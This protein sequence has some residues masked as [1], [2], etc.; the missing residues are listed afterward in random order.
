MRDKPS[1]HFLGTVLRGYFAEAHLGKPVTPSGIWDRMCME[2]I[3]IPGEFTHL[4]EWDS[5]KAS[6]NR[7]KTIMEVIEGGYLPGLRLAKH[8]RG[9]AIVVPVEGD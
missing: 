6:Q 3:M 7:I 1:E 9:G 8:A 2:A 4:M 5:R